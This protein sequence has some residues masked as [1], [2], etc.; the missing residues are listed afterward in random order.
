M[1]NYFG[2]EEQGAGIM[3]GIGLAG[4]LGFAALGTG[5]GAWQLGWLQTSPFELVTLFLISGLWNA[6]LMAAVLS[7]WQ[8]F[9]WRA[10]QRGRLNRELRDLRGLGGEEGVVRLQGLVR[11]LNRLGGTPRMLEGALLDGADLSGAD[12]RQCNLRTARL[13]GANLQGALLDGADL[14]GA[15]L[16]GANLSRVSIKGSLLERANLE[17]VQLAKAEVTGANL[18]R[19]N[20][21]NVNLYGT[22]L[23]GANLERAQFAYGE[24][25]HWESEVHASVEDWIREKLDEKGAYQPPPRE[26]T[27]P[28]E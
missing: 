10:A 15:E 14:S 18:R 27:R 24:A 26:N 4:L 2:E 17:N 12:L 5:W 28:E 22:S 16:S 25:G 8:R 13:Q 11:E 1:Q 20:L 7:I 21:V 9:A 6:A 19:A 23:R 3:P